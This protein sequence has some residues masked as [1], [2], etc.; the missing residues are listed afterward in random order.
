[1]SGAPASD[2]SLWDSQTD[3]MP[4]D[5]VLLSCEGS[6]TYDANPQALEAY[7]NA[8]GRAFASHYHYAWFSGPIKSAGQNTYTAPADWGTHIATWEPPPG[9]QYRVNGDVVQ[10]LNG[11]TAPFPKGQALFQWLGLVGALGAQDAGAQQL[12][13]YA[14]AYDAR[15]GPS[16][17]PSQPW[18]TESASGNTMF[19]SFDT[20]VNAPNAP[21]GGLPQYCGRAVFSDMHVDGNPKTNDK[22]PPPGGCAN[23][24]LSPQE[25]VLEFMVFDL[26]SCVIPDVVAP[27]DAGVPNQ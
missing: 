10:T 4:Y 5:I 26:S 15:V 20:P 17:G 16:N 7:L 11:S 8:G 14:P 21:D 1:M 18:I 9:P 23:T 25:A 27:S 12:P 6:E 22:S 19:L 2:K 24:N 3:L 13:I